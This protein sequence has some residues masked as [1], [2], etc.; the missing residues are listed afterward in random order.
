MLEELSIWS[1]AVCDKN[2]TIYFGGLRTLKAVYPNGTIKWKYSANVEATPAV[3]EDGT[4]Y[5]GSY[6]DLLAFYPNGTVKWMYHTGETIASAVTIGKDGTI[7]VGTMEGILYAI[8]PNGSTLWTIYLGGSLIS[9]P[10]IG[11]NNTIY[12]GTTSHF[13]FAV[14]NTG[15]L[16]WK[17]PGGQFKGTPSISS[18]G[19]IYAPSFDGYLYALNTNGTMK[20]RVSTGDSVAGAGVALSADGTI[21]IGTER[22]RAYF[23]NGTL[24]WSIDVKGDI[25]GTVPAV[26][27]DGTIY[28]SAGQFLVAINPDGNEKWRKQLTLGEIH[29]SPSIGA[30]DRVYIGADTDKSGGS[31]TLHVFGIGQAKNISIIVPKQG[32]L[33]IFSKQFGQ[34]KKGSTVVIGSVKIEVNASVVQDID[35]V[36]FYIAH[37]I[38]FDKPDF[39]YTYTVNKPP[40]EWTMNKRYGNRVYPK[41][42]YD[43][44]AIM[45]I[46]RYDG[47]CSYT[48]ETK[49]FYIHFI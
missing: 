31:G 7:Y 2:G 29:S 6:S 43:W 37:F 8:S 30:N 19:T 27:S 18:D 34:T 40:F 12:I 21:Y 5:L 26:S 28:V 44:M 9:S 46:G 39:Q 13:L 11:L 15:T 10:T 38:D 47:G 33:Y 1:S 49:I 16:L 41:L 45:A 25:Y 17:F 3:A 14:N 35:H 20:W 4:I 42:P 48:S 32:T 22:L 23:P 36:D 24:K